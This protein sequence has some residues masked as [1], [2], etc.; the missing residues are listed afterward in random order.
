VF[1]LGSVG[2]PLGRASSIEFNSVAKL[3]ARTPP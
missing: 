2:P 1:I 3:R